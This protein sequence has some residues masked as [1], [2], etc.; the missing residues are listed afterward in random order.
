[1]NHL[2][3]T[4]LPHALQGLRVVER[5]GLQNPTGTHER[6]HTKVDIELRVRNPESQHGVI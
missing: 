1:M 6:P 2:Q 4:L 3:F 5:W